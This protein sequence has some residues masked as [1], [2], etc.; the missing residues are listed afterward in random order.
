MP[1]KGNVATTQPEQGTG[2]KIV[3]TRHDGGHLIITVEGDSISKLIEGAARRL[4]YAERLK[5]GMAQAGIEA[6]GGTYVHEAEAAQAKTQDRAVALWR[7]DFRIT[8][9]I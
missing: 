4:A 3:D 5:H 1:D 9:M 7:A 2:L 8:P 6:L